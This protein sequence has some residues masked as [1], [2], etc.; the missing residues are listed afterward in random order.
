MYLFINLEQSFN[1]NC[2]EF[3][4]SHYLEVCLNLRT[5]ITRIVVDTCIKIQTSFFSV[6][7]AN[8]KVLYFLL[9]TLLFAQLN[10][11][12]I[13]VTGYFKQ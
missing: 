2:A 7:F 3:E 13:S 6:Q 12:N 10:S 4:T 1:L 9:H 8:K 11:R 5:R